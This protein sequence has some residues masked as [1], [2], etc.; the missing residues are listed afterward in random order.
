MRATPHRAARFPF[1]KNRTKMCIVPVFVQPKTAQ[2]QIA[3][4]TYG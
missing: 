4:S 3:S 1:R 2:M